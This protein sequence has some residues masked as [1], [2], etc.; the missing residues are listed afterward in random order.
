MIIWGGGAALT[1]NSAPTY[2]DGAAWN[3]QSDAWRMIADPPLQPRRFHVAGWTG[4]EM[5]IWGGDDAGTVRNDG[6]AYDPADDTWRPIAAS[7]VQWKRNAAAVWTGA[8]WVIATTAVAGDREELQFA[9][10]NPDQDVWR[11][12]PPLESRLETETTLVSM[13]P[14]LVV[15]NVNTGLQ[16]LAAGSAEWEPLPGIRPPFEGPVW[17]GAQLFAIDLE[18]LGSVEPRYRA[19]LAEWQPQSNTW[20][21]IV[22]PYGAVQDAGLVGADDHVLLLGGDLVYDTT[23]GEWFSADFPASINRVGAVRVWLGDRLVI[24]GGGGGDPSRAFAGGAVLTP[25]W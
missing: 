21:L 8:E 12:L 16:R 13:G 14:D 10:Y 17:T 1:S 23:T 11:E 22:D 24:W 4:T 7:P 19:T 15:L 9:A 20:R 5:I 6:A 25:A 2:G 3:P 18:Y